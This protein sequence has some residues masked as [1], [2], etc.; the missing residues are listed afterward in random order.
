M[1]ENLRGL[2]VTETDTKTGT[3]SDTE[4]DIETDTQTDTQTENTK[5]RKLRERQERMRIKYKN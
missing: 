4:T 1:N 5:L 2:R 3:Q